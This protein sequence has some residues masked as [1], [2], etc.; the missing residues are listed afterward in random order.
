MDREQEEAVLRITAQYIEEVHAGHQP[1]LSDYLARYPQ[2]AA[3]IADFVAYYHA[4]EVDVP[5]ETG[6]TPPLT[7]D[8]H[9][10][11]DS[12]WRHILQP[13]ATSTR[14][15]T[16]LLVTVNQQRLTL[17]QL[18]D[19]VGL[20]VDIVAKLEQRKIAASSIPKEM[21]KRLAQVLQLPMRAIEAYFESFD[22]PSSYR[23]QVA[24][25][26]VAYQV[27]EPLAIPVQSFRE[28]LE[29]S[30]R[31]SGQQKQAWYD[32]LNHEGL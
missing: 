4:V 22:E 5:G 17:S 13:G 14:N 20:S 3:E 15:L 9:I 31:L 26:Q 21:Y 32:M 7:E 27:N 29:E 18:A 2:F 16:T 24:E 19:K 28:A 30:V 6:I 25:A 10:A 8:F 23:S 1:K 12:A 11:I